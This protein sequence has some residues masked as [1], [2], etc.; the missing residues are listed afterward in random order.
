M[1]AT[2]LRG[3]AFVGVFCQERGSGWEPGRGGVRAQCPP[4]GG[5]KI[6]CRSTHHLLVPES[7]A[8]LPLDSSLSLQIAWGGLSSESGHRL[9][10]GSGNRTIPSLLVTELISHSA[11]MTTVWHILRHGAAK[12]ICF[13]PVHG[14]AQNYP[15]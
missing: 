15:A 3:V 1:F 10:C 6:G 5:C 14:L 8:P 13:M 2:H 4:A 9:D 12:G 11:G 7:S